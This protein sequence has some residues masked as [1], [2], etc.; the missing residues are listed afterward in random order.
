[1]DDSSSNRDLH[2]MK[3]SA[4]ASMLWSVCQI[5][6]TKG[7]WQNLNQEYF[8]HDMGPALVEKLNKH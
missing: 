7:F 2:L 3:M 5:H 8:V 1:M 4:F 6:T